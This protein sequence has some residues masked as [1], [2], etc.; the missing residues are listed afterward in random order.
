MVSTGMNDLK[1]PLP[2]LVRHFW[3]SRDQWKTKHHEVKRQLKKEQN[4]VR[5]LEKSRAV[6]RERA[7]DADR[8]IK[9]LQ[10]ELD[11]AKK[12]SAAAA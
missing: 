6:W 8:R 5:D 4:Q 7:T 11:E 1:S 3:K 10:Q 2:K 12:R 9:E